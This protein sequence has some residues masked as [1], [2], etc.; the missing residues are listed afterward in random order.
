MHVRRSEFDELLFRHAAK[1]GA[2]T[3]EGQRVKH[4]DMDAGKTGDGRSIVKV[5]GDDGVETTWRPRFVVDASGR[6]TLL[7]NQFDA[8]Q[9]NRKHAS[10]ALFGHFTG[11]AAHA[12]QAGRQHHA[13]LVRPRLVLVHPAA[14]RHHQRRR[15]GA[16]RPTSRSTARAQARAT[17]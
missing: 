1:Q 11:A 13:V 3:F 10:A 8:K 4:V 9:R 17:S 16:S 12:G 15:G 5:T 7:A 2:R 14:R 6:D